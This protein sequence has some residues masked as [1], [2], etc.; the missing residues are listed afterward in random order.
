MFVNES[1]FVFDPTVPTHYTALI[2]A[3]GDAA[4]WSMSVVVPSRLDYWRIEIDRRPKAAIPSGDGTVPAD[5]YRIRT[6]NRVH[7][8]VFMI[9][10][11]AAGIY[12]PATDRLFVEAKYPQLKGYMERMFRQAM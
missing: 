9:D 10:G 2:R 11:L 5:V 7:V 1:L 6:E 4:P 8:F 3:F 12:C